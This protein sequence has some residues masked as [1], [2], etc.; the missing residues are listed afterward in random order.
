MRCGACGG[1]FGEGSFCILCGV[2]ADESK[3][4]SGINNPKPVPFASVRS[5]FA[6]NRETLKKAAVVLGGAAVLA[7]A[8]LYLVFGM[9]PEQTLDRYVT[10]IREGSF[11]ALLDPSL[12]PGFEASHV[13]LEDLRDDES[14]SDVKYQV[15]N[16]RDG[17]AE[18]KISIGGRNYK[19]ELKSAVVF[20]NFFFVSE[21]NI[22]SPAP[23]IRLYLDSAFDN[24]Q[25]IKIPTQNNSISI[26]E[27]RTRYTR[28]GAPVFV[29]PGIY[30]ASIR[31][32][33]FLDD[34]NEQVFATSGIEKM[35]IEPLLRDISPTNLGIASRKASEAVKT[36]IRARCSKLP[37]LGEYDFNLWQ[38]YNYSTY[39][40]SRFNKSFKFEK[41]QES[42]AEVISTKELKLRFSC[43]YTARGHLYVRYTY[44]RGWY[45]DYYYYWNL[46]DTKSLTMTAEVTI[47]TN[48]AFS[49]ISVGSAQ[50]P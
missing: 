24:P 7:G 45:S 25:K 38:R 20:K 48:E 39:T 14:S 18:A 3:N 4:L 2:S 32:T 9:G 30:S 26:D 21:W 10:S 33:G 49:K 34:S 1:D 42:G 41:C 11:D 46:Y 28:L 50:I 37:K 15:E 23:Q 17:I 6:S 22:T 5:W 27:F 29:L 12:Y 31:G 8:Q 35:E 19:V 36:C 43:N 47:F 16:V 13:S 44:Y 40:S